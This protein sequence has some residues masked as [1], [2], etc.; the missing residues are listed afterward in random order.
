MS[1]NETACLPYRDGVHLHVK[2]QAGASILQNGKLALLA[3]ISLVD[4]SSTRTDFD[5]AS[6]SHC[7]IQN[8][9][10]AVG[11]GQAWLWWI[12]VQAQQRCFHYQV[13][14]YHMQ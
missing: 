7:L 3:M 9:G 13:N 10:A 12:Y 1:W 8:P 14:Q 6:G 4:L 11:N 2:F 5:Q